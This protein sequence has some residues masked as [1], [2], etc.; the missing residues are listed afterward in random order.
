MIDL[1]LPA[2]KNNRLKGFDYSQNGV[3]FITICTQNK[4]NLFGDIIVGADLVS[5][6]MKLNTAG[7]M[8]ERVYRE[9][10]SSFDN[11]VS[12]HFV[13][14]PNHV[15]GMISIQRADTRSAP[16]T[17][18]TIGRVVQAFKSKTT[19]AY[20]RGV[21]NGSFLAFQK[22]L[23]QRNYYEHI[24]RDEDDYIIKWNYIN[25]NPARWTEDDEWRN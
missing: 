25:E 21:K 9:V 24:V 8:I 6:R 20:I 2:R 12:D 5:A 3:Y 13:I 16:T 7:Q 23:W 4:I 22:R 19:V 1:K 15:H 10:I 11:I 17:A 18:V 14:M